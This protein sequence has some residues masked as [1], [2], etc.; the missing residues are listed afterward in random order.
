VG[1]RGRALPLRY[2]PLTALW[3]AWAS[4]LWLAGRRPGWGKI[5]RGAALAEAPLEA[6]PAPLSR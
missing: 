1:V 3:R 6:E 5:P 2:R 4:F